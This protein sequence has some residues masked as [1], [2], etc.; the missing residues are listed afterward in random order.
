MYLNSTTPG[1][2]SSVIMPSGLAPKKQGVL[3]MKK[4]HFEIKTP[5]FPSLPSLFINASAMLFSFRSHCSIAMDWGVLFTNN[6]FI[7]FDEEVVGFRLATILQLDA[8]TLLFL[9]KILSDS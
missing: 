5:F 3:L 4:P 9:Y 8:V 7:V 6:S 1:V 2:L